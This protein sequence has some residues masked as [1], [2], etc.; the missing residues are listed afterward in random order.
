M[1]GLDISVKKTK[2][3]EVTAQKEHIHI[4]CQ[5]CQLEQ[6]ERFKYFGAIFTKRADSS[7]E[8]RIHLGMA[9]G[10]EQ[11]LTP[12]WKDR[13]LCKYIKLRLL[14][15]LVWSVGLYGC[16]SWMLKAVDKKR[17]EGFEMTAYRRLLRVSWTEH[18]TNASILEELQPS[19]R[20]LDIV[21]KRILQYF[22]HVVC[23]KK[24]YSHILESRIDGNH[25]RSRPTR[26]WT[27][28]VQDWCNMSVVHCTQ[29]ARD[30]QCWLEECDDDI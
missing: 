7:E 1:D 23:A 13:S 20:L 2:V 5:G 19:I 14:T 9:G 24:L 10:V 6:V 27:D 22:S 17:I 11:S 16:E 28:D 18:R 8:I 21:C 12:L 25:S 3:M 26:S 29:T 30:R 4:T 15:S